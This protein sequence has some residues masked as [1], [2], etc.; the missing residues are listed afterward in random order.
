M[1]IFYKFPRGLSGQEC[2]D[3]LKFLFVNKAASH[4]TV[5]NYFNEFYC[6]QR[7][8]KD[9]VRE[10]PPKTAVVSENIDAVRTVNW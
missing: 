1:N 7:S 10:G 3:E 6:G 8:L 9:E 2:I 4:S 5:K